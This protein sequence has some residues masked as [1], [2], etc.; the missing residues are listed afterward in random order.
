MF[1]LPCFLYFNIILYKTK[2]FPQLDLLDPTRRN[3]RDGNDL[4][5]DRRNR[6]ED[7]KFNNHIF[8]NVFASLL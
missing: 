7:E 5:V 6:T 1:V 8:L 4:V 3:A 2:L